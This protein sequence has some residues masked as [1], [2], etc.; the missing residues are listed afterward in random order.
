MRYLATTEQKMAMQKAIDAIAEKRGVSIHR[1]ANNYVS[2]GERRKKVTGARVEPLTYATLTNWRKH[3]F[4]RDPD[5]NWDHGKASGFFAY[6]QEVYPDIGL[7]NAEPDFG[8]GASAAL[9]H[10]V[11]RHFRAPQTMP[12]ESLGGLT[13][14]PFAM[15]R[16]LWS[17]PDSDWIIR[18]IVQI[19]RVGDAFTFHETQAFVDPETKQLRSESDRG[20]LFLFG[21][22]V[23]ALTREDEF[24]CM[25]FLSM[26]RFD[27]G[28]N[29]STPVHV[30]WGN[31]IG[32]AGNQEHPGYRFMLRRIQ[33]E[34]GQ[35][36][37]EP[38]LIAKLDLD[39]TTLNWLY[40]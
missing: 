40:P 22:N 26:H 1:Q 27:P 15:F 5:P 10:V 9:L 21:S 17:N 18:S 8:S 16:R 39:R 34:D 33:A 25:K 14:G 7:E 38:R 2:W 37:M 28:L 4:V 13:G 36:D 3:D 23:F 32:V 30:C 6:L 12:R 11:E 24:Q 31:L 29:G 20:Y 19:E 35:M